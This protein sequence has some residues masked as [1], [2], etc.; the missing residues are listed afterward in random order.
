MSAS[1]SPVHYTLQ[2]DSGFYNTSPDAFR[3]WASQ[4]YDCAL[5]LVGKAEFSPVPYFLLCRAMELALKAVHLEDKRQPQVRNDFGHDL[6]KA[7][8]ALPAAKQTLARAEQDVL[9]KA[10]T[11]YKGKG[12]EYFNLTHARN[13]YSDYPDL[14]AL[15]AL[16]VAVLKL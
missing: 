15:N 13:G 7:Y 16:T 1:P 4:F 5:P 2:G 11:I 12:F 6:V 14:E 9:Q 8:D 3:E 10:S